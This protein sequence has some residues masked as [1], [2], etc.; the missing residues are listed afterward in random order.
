MQVSLEETLIGQKLITYQPLRPLR[1]NLMQIQQV[2]NKISNIL[3]GN[4]DN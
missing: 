3:K 2:I 1:E 4:R